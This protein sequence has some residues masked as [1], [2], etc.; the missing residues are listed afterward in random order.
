MSR[1]ELA[2]FS[3][4]L[5]RYSDTGL[6]PQNAVKANNVKL[7]S[8]E[9]RPWQLPVKVYDCQKPGVRSI[10]RLRGEEHSIWLE[11][12]TDVDVCYSPLADKTG[13]RI[14]YTEEG[15][16]KKTTYNMAV[17][18]TSGA[19]PRKWYY[20]GTPAPAVAPTGTANLASEEAENIQTVSYVYTYVSEFDGLEEESAPS[21][22]SEAIEATYDKFSVNVVFNKDAGGN[23][24]SP[25]VPTDHLNIT[26]IRLYRVV[27]GSATATYLEVD[28]LPLNSTTHQLDATGTS[29]EGVQWANFTYTDTRE[30]ASLSKELDSMYYNE[31][32]DGMSGLVSMPNGFLA[33]F[34]NNEVYFSEPFLPHAWPT[35]YMLTVDAPIVG[36]GVYGN[37][38]VVCTQRHPYTISGTHPASMTQEKQPMFQPCMSKRSI[39]YDQYGVVYA[40]PYGLVAMAGGQMDVFTRPIIT[41]DEWKVYEP[42]SFVAAMYDNLYMCSYSSSIGVG[43]LIFSRSDKPELVGYDYNTRAMHVERLTGRLFCVNEKD[44]AVYEMDADP[45]NAGVYE[46]M[47]KRFYNQYWTNYSALRVDADYAAIDRVNQWGRTRKMVL[48]HNRRALAGLLGRSSGGC[49]NERPLNWGEVDAFTYTDEAGSDDV[50]V[51]VSQAVNGSVMRL[52]PTKPESVFVNVIGYNEGE[53]LFSESLTDSRSVRLPAKKGD[54]WQ[55]R[56]IGNMNVRSVILATTM[57][58]LSSPT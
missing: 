23:A 53:L 28:E 14:Y 57:R 38:L 33:A 45:I 37:T 8:G 32:P 41:K 44:N 52:L 31:P 9:I 46:W 7:S 12:Q 22:A 58:E 5:P 17:D 34:R 11:F 25:A 35:T 27:T 24:I 16:C 40:S 43:L 15:K 55:F 6:P 48:E 30:M 49:L 29:T 20:M 1:V 51:A 54:F 4:I 18:G 19:Y 13:N 36:L 21:Q 39:A 47:S 10:F 3:G 50:Q 2:N 42:R 56:V 26:K